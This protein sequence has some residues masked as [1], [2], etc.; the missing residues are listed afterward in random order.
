MNA[1]PDEKKGGTVLVS[2]A[3]GLI[4]GRLLPELGRRFGSVRIL[5]RSPGGG[6]DGVERIVWDGSDPGPEALAG[7]NAV[8]HLAG[9]PVFGGAPTAAR[10][11]RIRSSRIDS[12]RAIVDR[13][14]EQDADA[15]PACLVCASAVGFY[16]DRGEEWLDEDARP[17]DGFLAE[18]CRD[19]E[20]EAL[21]AEALG[22][23]VVRLRIGVVLARDGGALS[24]MQLPFR[25]GVGG[26][27]GDGR[28]FF[29]W[30]HVEDMVRVILFA[31]DEPVSGALNAVAPEAA[32]NS[33]L[34]RALGRVLRR[35][36]LLP[37]PGFALRLALGVFSG[38]LLGSRRVRPARLEAAGFE[39]R[40]PGLE[41]ALAVELG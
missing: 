35:P 31:L 37:V 10:Q 25:L 1:R 9:E 39:W 12:T 24:L 2:G 30:I 6:A 13:I 40:H 4:G 41:A 11:R 5:S 18:V 7:V 26:R 23:R 38:E 16:G 29:P 36:T 15:R 21:R 28:Q 33:E 3:T 22:V 14:A 34:T 20:A 32:R 8:V 19:W 27:L 17:G